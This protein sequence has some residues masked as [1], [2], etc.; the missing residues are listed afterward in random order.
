MWH[1]IDDG[2]A[3]PPEEHTPTWAIAVDICSGSGCG[4]TPCVAAKGEY[5]FHVQIRK[6]E[7][8]RK[9]PGADPNVF[10]ETTIIESW[11][12]CHTWVDVDRAVD[13][14]VR[15]GKLPREL[16]GAAKKTSRFSEEAR[17][18]LT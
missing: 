4:I 16:A 2:G 12:V 9:A 18:F 11:R 10:G 1:P 8:K 17:R 13:E 5:R 14:I 3:E 6:K 15:L 7:V